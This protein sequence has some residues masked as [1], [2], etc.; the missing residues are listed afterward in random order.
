MQ[1]IES[2]F[3]GPPVKAWIEGVP[4]EEDAIRQLQNLTSLPFVEHVAVMPDCH[5]GVGAT[6]GSVIA[7]KGAIIPSAVG[8]DL[9][10]G[11]SALRTSLTADD[12]PESL[13]TLRS[14][15]ERAVP[16]GGPGPSGGWSKGVP[17]SV[18]TRWR[19]LEPR[20][21]ALV[22]KNKAFD[23]TAYL[24]QLGTLGGGNHFV[25]VCLD[26]S[27]RV[28]VMLH[29]GSRG[30]GNRIGQTYIARAREMLMQRYGNGAVPDKDLAW[31]E[32]GEPEFS[33]YMEAVGWAQDYAW[34]NRQQMMANVLRVM[35]EAFP[36]FTTDK[37]AVNNHHNAV[38]REEHFGQNL[39]V[40]RKGATPAGEGVLG[41]IPG[42]MGAK[43]YIVRGKGN[44]DSLCSC[45][46]GAGRKMSRGA[47]KRAFSVEDLI[48]QTQGVNCRTDQGVL[49][50]IPGAYKDI[51]QVMAAQAD[52]VSIEHTL[53]AV[54]C[55]KG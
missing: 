24:T 54:L 14:A 6:I 19:G 18:M 53:K 28:W 1:F 20:F 35:R 15:I 8:V 16:H 44:L 11:M 55:V 46:H 23:E 49:D 41:I 9:G 51:D 2:I 42:S 7:T 33:D 48:E 25:E 10:C 39:L 27:D 45:S 17:N 37:E 38:W 47:A 5:V 43:S 3:G 13:D 52:L 4:V 29:S 21:K 50:E 34:E 40:T 22:E 31:F 30:V 32:E 36:S 12:L 26:E